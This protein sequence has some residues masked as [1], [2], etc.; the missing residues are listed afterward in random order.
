[1]N[2]VSLGE[3]QNLSLSLVGFREELVKLVVRLD[4]HLLRLYDTHFTPAIS[5]RTCKNTLTYID[6]QK[7]KSHS[8]FTRSS[9]DTH[10]EER[11][12]VSSWDDVYG[13]FKGF[14]SKVSV[15]VCVSQVRVSIQKI[16]YDRVQVYVFWYMHF[17][18]E[19]P[20]MRQEQIKT[21]YSKTQGF[22]YIRRDVYKKL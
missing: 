20:S 21:M 3:K 17:L 6:R 5:L 15:Y 8:C 4:R 7:R 11:K 18:I 1:M 13:Y 12:F 10:N 9:D 2:V 16:W 19:T 22:P 14:C